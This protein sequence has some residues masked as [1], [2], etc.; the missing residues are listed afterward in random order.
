MNDSNFK[1]SENQMHMQESQIDFFYQKA[2][3]LLNYL[4]SSSTYLLFIITRFVMLCF[5]LTFKRFE[6]TETWPTNKYWQLIAWICYLNS[7]FFKG[8]EK[9]MDFRPTS[10]KTS[11]EKNFRK[12]FY[13]LK[14]TA[15]EFHG[16]SSGVI[17]TFGY[18]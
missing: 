9:S 16:D 8:S 12:Q 11:G 2:L 3:D 4:L 6:M 14:R 18:I 7:Y 13:W 15:F 17:F 10:A 1:P 5:I